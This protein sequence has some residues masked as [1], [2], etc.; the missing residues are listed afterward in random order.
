MKEWLLRYMIVR[1]ECI[2][3]VKRGKKLQR[4]DYN[5][6]KLFCNIFL[7]KVRKSSDYPDLPVFEIVSVKDNKTYQLLVE[8]DKEVEEWI[9]VLNLK[10]QR[11]IENP[12]SN[13]SVHHNSENIISNKTHILDGNIEVIN[14][15][16]A[17]QIANRK[18][19]EVYEEIK[20]IVDKNICADCKTP[21]PEW[22]SNNLG[23]LV[24][25]ACSG[26]HRGLSTDV[27]R[28]RSLTLDLLTKNTL[29]F[30]KSV[31]DNDINRKVFESKQSA[32]EKDR[33]KSGI[34]E[35]ISNKYEKRKY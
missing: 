20:E 22:F 10:V 12:M 28:V 11:L 13:D 26:F 8:S 16:N 21:F 27:S 30:L 7:A 9:Q 34:K 2:F 17:G 15:E 32:V 31:I 6:A 35:I 5:D 19:A 18:N 1:D 14:F 4:Y 3:T 23:V 29:R 24:C 25:I 33:K